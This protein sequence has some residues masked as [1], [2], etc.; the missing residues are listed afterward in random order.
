MPDPL[1]QKT[2]LPAIETLSFQEIIKPVGDAGKPSSFGIIGKFKVGKTTL[3][4]TASKIPSFERSGKKMLIMEA[5]KGTAAIAEEFPTIDQAPFSTFSGFNRAVDELCT[6]K[7]DYGIVMIDTF[8]RFQEM[9]AAAYLQQFSADTRAAYGL[10]K[11]W[12]NE[13]VWKLHK[14]N[15]FVI[16]LFHET[17]DKKEGATT[18]TTTFKLAG[19]AKDDLGQIFD[20]IGR[21]TVETNED[22]EN[23]RVLQV[24]PGTGMVTGSR[25]E[26]KLPNK[27]RNPTLPMIFDMIEA[28]SAPVDDTATTTATTK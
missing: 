14:A 15:F 5:E 26:K 21:L 11:Q 24:G 27:V 25:W 7:H 18:S 13:V 12:T 4:A 3:G 22:G 1:P 6:R 9:A 19:S 16:F 17:D 8:D 20:L 23:E 10:V 28:K 2:D